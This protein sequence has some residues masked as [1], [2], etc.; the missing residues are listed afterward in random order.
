MSTVKVAINGFGRI[1]R[2]VFRQIYNMQGIDVV[3]V[4]DLTSPAV[5]AHLLK[6]DS[7]QGRF[8]QNVTSTENAIIVDGHEI[9]V[10]INERVRA[11]V[12]RFR[13]NCGTN[14]VCYHIQLCGRSHDQR[15]LT[16]IFKRDDRI[17]DRRSV[18]GDS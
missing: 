5:L 4:N 9:V 6:Y 16:K 1:G 13:R 3:A 14:P 7:A 2:L 17:D 11:D 12:E 15:I 10:K 18:S 8:G